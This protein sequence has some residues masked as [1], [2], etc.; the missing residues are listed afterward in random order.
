MVE[1]Y[2]DIL[3]DLPILNSTPTPFLLKDV[4][5]IPDLDCNLL[6]VPQVLNQSIATVF[7]QQVGGSI[8]RPESYRIYR[9]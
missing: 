9:Y 4:W 6:S 8:E 3:V 1:G 7:T 2:W 5:Y